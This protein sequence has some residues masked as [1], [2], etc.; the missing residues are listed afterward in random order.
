[1]SIKISELTQYQKDCQR[2]QQSIDKLAEGQEKTKLQSLLR[3]YKN[4]VHR[5][6][7]NLE[8]IVFGDINKSLQTQRLDSQKMQELRQQL[9]AAV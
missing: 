8:N 3:D 4:L 5:M 1:M 6:D 9:E 7:T 2:Y